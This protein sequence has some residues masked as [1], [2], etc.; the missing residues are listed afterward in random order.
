MELAQEKEDSFSQFKNLFSLFKKEEKL[1][2]NTEQYRLQKQ[3]T[4]LINNQMFAIVFE[5]LDG[6]YKL[7]SSQKEKLYQGLNSIHYA[8]RLEFFSEIITKGMKLSDDLLLDQFESI[9]LGKGHYEDSKEKGL[10][11]Q[12]E[13]FIK[14]AIERLPHLNTEYL[15]E[16]LIEKINSIYES[17][18]NSFKMVM[19]RY[20]YD[21]KL[22]YSISN[23]ITD[24]I[25]KYGDYLF[26]DK[27]VE[28]VLDCLNKIDGISQVFNKHFKKFD[29]NKKINEDYDNYKVLNNTLMGLQAASHKLKQIPNE[30][31]QK[32]IENDKKQISIL[33]GDDEINQLIAEENIKF[34]KNNNVKDLPDSAKNILEEIKLD[35]LQLNK[36]LEDLNEEE[37]FTV[38]NLWNK[39][40]P[41]I[42]NKYLRADPEFRSTMKNNNGQSI[43]DLMIDSLNNIHIALN[44]IN[45]NHSQN[46]LHDM[47]AINRYTK[48]IK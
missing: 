40:I 28:E 13:P 48:A 44:D 10:S 4:D 22:H 35:Y 36:R 23:N 15:Y 2:N 7:N 5:Y 27:S 30:Y 19:P 11:Y 29:T 37:K 45:M 6:G 3:I 9:M 41:E 14:F 16:N 42:I 17:T 38:D 33:F 32:Q 21:R 20:I 34:N 46:V 1:E 8:T 31:H 43:E 26:K 12:Y 18:Q 24:P 47:S 39:R 25:S